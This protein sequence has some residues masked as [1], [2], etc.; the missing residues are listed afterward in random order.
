MKVLTVF[1][2]PNPGSFCAAVLQQF[3]RGLA[4][5]G[6]ASKVIDLHAIRFDPVFRT[7]D[8]ANYVDERIPADV[9]ERMDLKKYV[10]DAARGRFQ[11]FV[12]ARWLRDKSVPD[13][14]KLIRTR[15]PKDVAAQ[16]ELVAWADGLAFIAPVIWMG[17]PAILKGWFERVFTLGF[18]YDLRPE[19]W[20][21]DLAGRVPLLRHQKALIIST[22]LFEAAAYQGAIGTAMK[23][24]MDDFALRY[25]GVKN[26]EHVYFHAVPVVDAATRQGYLERAYRLGRDFAAYSRTVPGRPE[27]A[28]AVA[29]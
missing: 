29:P 3:T 27:V 7:D 2:H 9:L 17:F 12:A 25:P 19:G 13:V 5:A 20:R 26:V 8:F 10:L 21:G 6:H 14:V 1:A 4:D 23:T 22:T 16:Q 11:R 15:R 24:L 28:A 18:A